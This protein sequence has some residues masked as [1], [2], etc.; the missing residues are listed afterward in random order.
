[1][2]QK[3]MISMCVIITSLAVLTVTLAKDP[4]EC[5][6]TEATEHQRCFGAVGQQLLFHLQETTNREIVL[7]KDDA[8]RVFKIV[9]NQLQ[10]LHADYKHDFKL[11]DNGTFKLGKVMKNYSGDY[12][13]QEFDHN[14][15]SLRKVHLHLEIQA[16]VSKPA[17]SQVCLSSQQMKVSC[18]C[19]GDDVGFILHLDDVPVMPTLCRAPHSSELSV[20]DVTVSLHG[21][22]TGNL[23]CLVFNNISREETILHLKS[24]RDEFPFFVIV[25]VASAAVTLLLFLVLGL[26]INHLKKLR[27]TA[28]D[29]VLPN[30]HEDEVVYSAVRMTNAK[31]S[32]SNILNTEDE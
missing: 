15:S 2:S 19:E 23:K 20:S 4:L 24:C 8:V 12:N 13:L 3:N 1:M 31:R 16:P 21:L 25:T 22:V 18:S 6:F 7:I 11:F 9:K 10:S 5:N 27:P 32:R 26:S 28:V 30:R 14:G 29:E 17:V